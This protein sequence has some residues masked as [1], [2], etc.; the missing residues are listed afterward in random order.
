LILA[1][2]THGYI[3]MRICAEYLRGKGRPAGW[4]VDVKVVRMVIVIGGKSGL[5]M[6][7]GVGD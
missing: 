5:E 2:L 1:R 4:V 3:D 7:H 6:I